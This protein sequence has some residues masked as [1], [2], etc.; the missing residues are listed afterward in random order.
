MKH[1]ELR[2]RF[3]LE[4]LI[5]FPTT[6][7]VSLSAPVLNKDKYARYKVLST[8][9]FDWLNLVTSQIVLGHFMPREKGIAFIVWSYI[10]FYASVSYVIFSSFFTH[11]PIKCKWFANRSSWPID[12]TLTS[13]K[14]PALSRPG[15]NGY[16]KVPYTHQISRTETLPS[17]AV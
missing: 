2:P 7:T 14:T 3:E 8:F 12:E 17:N 15:S 6:M 4:S 16:E 9:F 5:P 1:T 10:Y 13:T 11:S